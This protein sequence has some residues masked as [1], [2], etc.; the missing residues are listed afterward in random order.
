M[1]LRLIHT[2]GESIVV[3]KGMKH[4]LTNNTNEVLTII[5]VQYG[6]YFGEDNIIRITDPYDR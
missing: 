6:N 2:I 1:V 4:S 3:P 5:E